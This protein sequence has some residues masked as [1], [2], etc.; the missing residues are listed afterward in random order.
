[1]RPALRRLAGHTALTRPAVTATLT[2]AT[3]H[4]PGR[5]SY[6][7]AMVTRTP[8]GAAEV[9]ALTKQGSG[10]LLPM[11]EA[12]ALLVLHADTEALPAGA[13][14]TVLVLD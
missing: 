2:E 10:M 9:R 14:V 4:T 8:E 7:R 5:Q 13:A 3:S 12:N 11:T 1:M 6:Q